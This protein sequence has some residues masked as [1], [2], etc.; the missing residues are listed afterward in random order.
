MSNF[1]PPP[2]GG[3]PPYEPP[4]GGQPPAGQPPVPPAGQPQYQQP[5]DPLAEADKKRKKQLAILSVVGAILIVAAFFGGKALE[6]KN[7]EPGKDGYNEIYAEGAKRGNAAG[8][9]AGTASGQKEGEKAGKEAGKSEG[10]AEGTEKGKAEGQAEGEAEGASQALGGL[11]SWSTTAPY[12][13]QMENGPSSD[14]PYTVSSRTPMQPGIFYKICSSGQGVCTEADNN[15]SSSSS[16]GGS[17][18]S[19]E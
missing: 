5:V 11:S 2:P 9:A 13:V 10:I 3:Q 17:G 8:E 7:Y 14:V 16:A 15:S 4:P 12:V 18:A 6:K 19:G 1:P